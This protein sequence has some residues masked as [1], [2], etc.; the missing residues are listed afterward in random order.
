MAW[1][2]EIAFL[3]WHHETQGGAGSFPCWVAVVLDD[4]HRQLSLYSQWVTATK[5]SAMGP[6]LCYPPGQLRARIEL[7]KWLYKQP[8]S[9]WWRLHSP[10]FCMGT[11]KVSPSETSSVYQMSG[12]TMCT[13]LQ[14][15]LHDTFGG[16]KSQIVMRALA[17][18]KS[19]LW[20]SSR[21][22]DIQVMMGPRKM[23]I[24][25]SRGAYIGLV[26]ILV[27]SFEISNAAS[28]RTF[29]VMCIMATTSRLWLS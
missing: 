26:H 15:W 5:N 2:A 23:Y 21:L 27:W 10:M 12:G 20:P 24:G 22:W 11:K 9:G 25:K 14:P 1:R 13:A 18:K 29:R 4:Q 7:A 16:H 17:S 19:E 3:S 8:D 6:A 28:T